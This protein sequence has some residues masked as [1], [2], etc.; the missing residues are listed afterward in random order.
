M[1]LNLSKLLLLLSST[2]N[3]FSESKEEGQMV[4]TDDFVSP[5]LSFGEGQFE[6]YVQCLAISFH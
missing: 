4:E 1:G 6:L 2:P 5:R 3:F